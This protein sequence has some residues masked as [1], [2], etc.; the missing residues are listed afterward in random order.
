MNSSKNS[1]LEAVTLLANSVAFSSEF[2]TVDIFFIASDTFDDS[3]L[4]VSISL[5]CAA[6]SAASAAALASSIASI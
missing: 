5:A 4:Y 1:N 6:A 2:K 3:D